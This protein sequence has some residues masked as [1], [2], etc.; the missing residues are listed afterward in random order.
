MMS[1]TKWCHPQVNINWKMLTMARPTNNIDTSFFSRWNDLHIQKIFR[2]CL[3]RLVELTRLKLATTRKEERERSINSIISP[4]LPS[5]VLPCFLPILSHHY[6][7]QLK[8]LIMKLLPDVTLQLFAFSSYPPLNCLFQV[9]IEMD[10]LYHLL[11]QNSSSS[12]WILFVEKTQVVPGRER[13][14][15]PGEATRREPWRDDCHHLQGEESG[16]EVYHLQH[17]SC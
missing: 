14:W 9:V 3:F 15:H 17:M 11:P 13:P 8:S 4:S 12:L 10:S 16:D 2:F 7:Y 6:V 1:I 5:A